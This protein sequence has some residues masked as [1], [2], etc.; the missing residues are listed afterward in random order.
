[1]N[2]AIK[3]TIFTAKYSEEQIAKADYSSI[4]KFIEMM[5][6]LKISMQL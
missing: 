2:N 1:M 6:P 4:K 5:I 3:A